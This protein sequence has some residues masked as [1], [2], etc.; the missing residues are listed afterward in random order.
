MTP[1]LAS[2]ARIDGSHLGQWEPLTLRA[3]QRLE[4]N[5]ENVRLIVFEQGVAVACSDTH[6]HPLE[7]AMLLVLP[8][9]QT[10][11]L[12]A[13]SDCSLWVASVPRGGYWRLQEVYT[14][15]LETLAAASAMT[16]HPLE[17][18]SVGDYVLGIHL[19]H[20][21]V[22]RQWLPWISLD[23]IIPSAGQSGTDGFLLSVC[24]EKEAGAGEG[25]VPVDVA[26]IGS[27][28]AGLSVA[29]HAMEAGLTVAVYG[30]PMS[31]WKRS[32]VPLPL[33]SQPAGTSID[34][35]RKGYRYLDFA[36]RNGL[37]QL[38]YVPF[39]A[40]LAYTQNFIDGHGI[41]FRRSFVTALKRDGDYWSIQTDC[42]TQLARNVVVAVGLK[43][44]ERIP[45]RVS[46][47]EG[48]YLVASE[49][50]SF[51][52]FRGKKVAVVGSGQSAV[53]LALEISRIPGT[54]VTLLVRGSDVIFRS[55]HSPGNVIYKIMFKKID[56]VFGLLPIA[57]Q[58]FL[59]KFLMKG[60]A[61][62][63]IENRLRSSDVHVFPK[64]E[65]AGLTG[66]PGDPVTIALSDGS[67]LTV[68]H[69]VLGTGYRFDVRRVPFLRALVAMGELRE[70]GG[71]PVLS[72][73]A[74]SSARGLFFAGMSALRLIGPQ[75][76]F[77][78]GTKKVTPRIV[79]A[80]SDRLG[81]RH[82]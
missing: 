20:A 10:H 27:G 67:E 21:P 74:E 12:L 41:R 80:I 3:G 46:A 14:C 26:V 25:S 64:V 39:H 24:N 54:R 71:L 38:P 63:T 7:R 13:L 57:V 15:N 17:V 73:S 68:D 82:A 34:T 77:V 9:S 47:W 78:F 36:E 32:I 22:A 81:Q 55:I 66:A 45:Q 23:Q 43:G 37:S 29:A 69:L 51:E 8:G 18:T 28:P 33:R 59:L 50:Q 60:T 31:F 58:D 4:P 72:S 49:L 40:F 75:C 35:P 16:D 61:E 1:E 65:I 2:A 30:Q 79:R 76:Q 56:K 11:Q 5:T 52:M 62:P 48:R 19:R 70:A 42:G 44:M 53:E 6:E